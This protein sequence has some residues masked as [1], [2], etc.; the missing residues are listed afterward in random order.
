[1]AVSPS[2]PPPFLSLTL[3]PSPYMYEETTKT[4]THTEGAKKGQIQGENM[5]CD[6]AQKTNNAVKYALY[7][8]YI[9]HTLC[10]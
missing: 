1:M 2:A 9:V 7:C 3:D 8:T 4:V 6:M 10:T 5:Y